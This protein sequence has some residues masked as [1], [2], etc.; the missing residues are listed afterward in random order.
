MS[1]KNA[2]WARPATHRAHVAH[3][4][5]LTRP[6]AT[7]TTSPRAPPGRRSATDPAR[8]AGLADYSEWRAQEYFDTYYRDTVLPDE[9]QVLAFQLDALACERAAFGRALEYGCGPTLHRAIA[10]AHHAFRIDM[11]DRS[12]DNLRQ[13]RRWLQAGAHG[14]E[15]HRFTRFILEHERGLVEPGAIERREALTRK[16]VRKLLL[17][18]ARRRYPLGPERLGFYD[19]LISGFCIDAISADKRI[20]HECMGNVLALLRRGARASRSSTRPA[21][22]MRSTATREF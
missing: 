13:I 15:W 5:D 4:R 3:R 22:R 14:T 9:R 11:A 16:V 12:P 7:T 20:W 18:D 17:S 1:N 10:A 2:L 6:R 19:L 21:P 8:P